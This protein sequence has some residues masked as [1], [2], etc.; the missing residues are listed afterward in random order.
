MFVGFS[1][2]VRGGLRLGA[3][4]RVTKK[5]FFYMALIVMM[6]Y[7]SYLTI[8][9]SIW[10]IVGICYLCFVLPFKKI[11]QLIKGDKSPPPAPKNIIEES[12]GD[13]IRKP[14][15]KR[16]YVWVAGIIVISFIIYPFLPDDDEPQYE[17]AFAAAQYEVEEAPPAYEPQD[18]EPAYTSEEIVYEPEDEEPYEETIYFATVEPTESP[19]PM[20]EPTST[21]EPSPALVIVS[22]P[23]RVWRNENVTITISGRPNEVYTLRVRYADWSNAAGLGD[24]TTDASGIASW[25]W[26][27]GG[28]TGARD[29]AL[30][31]ITGGGRTIDHIFEVVVD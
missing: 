6:Y 11:T 12:E 27:I 5:N 2:R 4:F 10:L 28:Q 23:D 17:A 30:A 20:P 18:E 15:H 26:Q 31:R 3:G 8:V 29:N 13:N 19:E 16:W 9:G 7:I 24:A 22:A 25:T 1:K 21:P 14:L